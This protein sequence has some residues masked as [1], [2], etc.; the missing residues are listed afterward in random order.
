MNKNN[1]TEIDNNLK[2]FPDN[3]TSL[4]EESLDSKSSEKK[5]AVRSALVRMGKTIIPQNTKLLN[6]DSADSMTFSRI[7]TGIVP[8]LNK[9]SENY[10]NT[11]LSDRQERNVT[12]L[13]MKNICDRS[14]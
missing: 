14:K 8:S 3:L 11:G 4:I 7:E 13:I 10:E 1:S 6:S 2:D 5:L 9:K 12:W